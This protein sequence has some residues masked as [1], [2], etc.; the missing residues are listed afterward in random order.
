[1]KIGVVPV[2]VIVFQV[3]NG[4]KYEAINTSNDMKSCLDA[5]RDIFYFVWNL[6]RWFYLVGYG[7]GFA[8]SFTIVLSY[9][10]TFCEID[11]REALQHA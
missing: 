3:M 8:N 6:N 4:K 11:I 9:V 10:C 7:S 2:A 5:S 1:M